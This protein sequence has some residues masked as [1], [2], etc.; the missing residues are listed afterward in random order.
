V[1]PAT[2]GSACSAEELEDQSGDEEDN[3]DRPQNRDCQN[4]S[5][6]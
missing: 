3:S 6:Y 1:T 5:D 2:D 4:E